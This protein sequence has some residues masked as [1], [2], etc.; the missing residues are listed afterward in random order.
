MSKNITDFEN[1]VMDNLYGFLSAKEY[2]EKQ[3]TVVR[4]II[5][6]S[7]IKD[8]TKTLYNSNKLC[9]DNNITK[10]GRLIKK[11]RNNQR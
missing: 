1:L 10:K 3:W 7:K 2:R 5:N 8:S 9:Y 4:R 6:C 11:I